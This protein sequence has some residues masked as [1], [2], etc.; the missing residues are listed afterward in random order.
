MHNSDFVRVYFRL[1]VALVVKGAALGIT[2]TLLF[3]FLF[4]LRLTPPLQPCRPSRLRLERHIGCVWSSTELRLIPGYSDRTPA[5]FSLSSSD[6]K[7]S[8]NSS[9]HAFHIPS[10]RVRDR[11][12]QRLRIGGGL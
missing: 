11:T 6:P 7:Q 8:S 5:A 10:P 4:S 9:K 2:V 3:S 12:G 1:H